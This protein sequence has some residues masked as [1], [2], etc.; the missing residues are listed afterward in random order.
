MPAVPGRAADGDDVGLAVAVEVGD[1]QVF[2]RD[3]AVVEDVPLPLRALA[4]GA[5]VDADAAALRELVARLRVRVVAHA[6]DEFVRAVAVEVREPDR[7]APPQLLV[8]DVAVPE[9]PARRRA[10]YVTTWLP[11]HGS[12]VAITPSFASSRLP[13]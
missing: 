5:L 6:D 1:G 11:C 10:V 12:M 7:V 13:A 9:L 2:H 8:D 3:A 4:V